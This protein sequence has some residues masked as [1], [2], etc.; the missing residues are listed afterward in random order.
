[1]GKMS[2]DGSFLPAQHT[3]TSFT[4]LAGDLSLKLVMNGQ[5][6]GGAISY[7]QPLHFTLGYENTASEDLNNIHLRLRFE[8][9]SSSKS[10]KELLDWKSIDDAE[11]GKIMVLLQRAKSQLVYYL[12]LKSTKGTR[13]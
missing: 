6:N 10:L 7:G 5:E 4:V 2:V 11:G 9:V 12:S 8:Q 3:E 13:Y 1:M